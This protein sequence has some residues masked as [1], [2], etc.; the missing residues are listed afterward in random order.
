MERLD[1]KKLKEVEAK[2][3]YHVEVSNNNILTYN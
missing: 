1:L 2:N 3:K